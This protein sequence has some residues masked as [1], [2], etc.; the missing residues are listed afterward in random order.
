MSTSS[1]ARRFAALVRKESYQAI[2]DP[3][4]ILIAFVL[5]LI[6]LFLFGY[7]VSLDT[8]RTRIALVLEQATPLTQDL[9]ASFQA[10]RYFS[11][12]VGRDRRMFE[13]DLVL[14]KV[15]GIVVISADFATDY[16]AGNRPQIQVLVDGS[17]PNTANFV[18][19]YA[20]GAVANWER[21]RRSETVAAGP[22]ISIEQRFWFNP[23]LTSRNFLVPGSIA[24]VMTLVGTLLTSL[25]VAREWERGTMEA[26]M[27]TP[28]TAAELLAGKI[29]PYFLLG[30][31]SMTLCVLLAVFL[32]GVPFRGSVAALYA[33]SAAFLIPAL[34][35]GLLI[36]TATK[37]QFLASQIALTSGFLP[38]F[39]L[40]GFL[41][42]INSMPRIIQWITII[43]PARYLIPSLQTVFLAGDIWPMF[44][45][46]IAVM[47]TIGGI[48]F[49]LA[50]RS[51]R[52]RIG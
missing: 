15:R 8:T 7:G 34:G 6:L 18:Q 13:N 40:S 26:M 10:S 17:D 36:S 19:N 3:S 47:L 25:V 35:Q 51:T 16:A 33:L 29:L 5:P 23:E 43:V 31:A 44:A 14:G 32:F 38:A 20:Q 48:M 2:R 4:T 21:Q 30:L 41:F 37:N 1:R 9:A 50:A 22:P 49:V 46:S 45:R 39:L 42:E 24:I 27:A 28:V 12:T 52:K 11:V